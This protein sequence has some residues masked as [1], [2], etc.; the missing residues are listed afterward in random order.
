MMVHCGGERVSKGELDLVTMPM[1]TATYMPVS[2]YHLANKIETIAMDLL[3]RDYEMV[4]ESYALA[5]KG[6][7]MFA[8]L[9][10]AQHGNKEIGLALGYRN[11]YD[12]SMALGFAGGG[13]VF[14]CDNLALS[15]E[16]TIMK[17]HTKNVWESFENEIV[18][19]IYKCKKT[20][21]QIL[22]DAERLKGIPMNNDEAFSLLG[23]LFGNDIISP[24]QLMTARREW[25]APQ[26]M[27]F[28]PRT[29]WSFYNACTES[30]KTTPPNCIMENHIALHRAINTIG[31]QNDA[32]DCE[33]TTG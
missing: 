21:M 19:I 16:I 2:H 3:S 8:L 7:Q 33:F 25:E 12:Q 23:K 20:H 10:F 1:Q 15:G 4:S 28:Q 6:N 11:S 14:V 31:R 27:E 22:E 5:R 26:H 30:L 17:K 29:L 9:N 18:G 13:D 24:R 32:I